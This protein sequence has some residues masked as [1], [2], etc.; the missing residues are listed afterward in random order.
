MEFYNSDNGSGIFI[1]IGAGAGDM[2]SSERDG[3]TEFIKKLPIDKIKQII[4]VEPNPLNIPQLKE[5]WKDYLEY[6]TIY[7]IVIVPKD[8]K[9]DTMELYYCP[10]D[11]PN[12]QVS[13]INKKHIQNHYGNNC[14]IN[15]FIISVKHLED[16]ID[17]LN[18]IDEIELLSLDIE[19]IDAEILLEINFNKIKLKYL[20]FEYIHLSNNRKNVLNYLIS[21]N[22]TYLGNGIDYKGFD[23]LYINNKSINYDISIFEEKKIIFQKNMSINRE[24]NMIKWIEQLC[25]KDKIFLDIGINNGLYT[26]LLADKFSKVYSFEPN[27]IQYNALCGNIALSNLHNVTC[28]NTN[29][30]NEQ[31]DSYNEF[32]NIGL[33]KIDIDVNTICVLQ[34]ALNTLIRSKYPTILI[35]SKNSNLDQ[36]IRDFINTLNYKIKKLTGYN[37]MFLLERCNKPYTITFSIPEEKIVKSPKIELKTKLVSNLIPGDLSTYIYNTEKEY[38]AEYQ[39]SYFAITI[40]KSGWDCMRHYEILAN[41]CIPYF[42]DIEKCPVGTMAQWPKDLLI[43]ANALYN[44]FIKLNNVE[45]LTTEL[46]DKYTILLNLL[47]DHLKEFLTTKSIAKYILKKTNFEHMAKILYLSEDILPDYLR[48]L[49]L[50]GFKELFGADCHDYPKIPHIYKDANYSHLYGKGI[51]YT[52]LLDKNLHNEELDKT[53]EENI[54]NKYYDVVVYGSYHRGMPFYSLVCESYANDEIILLCG[55][56]IHNCNY[57]NLKH[58]IFVREG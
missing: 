37:H 42:I 51:T 4:L 53:I 12:Y 2:D 52:N 21:N 13:S 25:A 17:E 50:H 15:S 23:Y 55:E 7:E 9:G 35:K 22:Y 31:L 27:K 41:G 38:Y 44:E 11:G 26:I 3:F 24:I 20:S 18:I 54:K 28:L 33:I 46:V 43:Q 30:S 47:L 1:Q 6:C 45:S 14:E 56:D 19:G 10:L 29:L 58:P 36:P 32:N 16:F 48:Y 34:G 39:K 40:K 57:Y 49:T 8:Y 5:C